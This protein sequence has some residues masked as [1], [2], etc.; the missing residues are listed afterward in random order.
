MADIEDTP[1]P[2]TGPDDPAP[3]SAPG[4]VEPLATSRLLKAQRLATGDDMFAWRVEAGASVV[5]LTPS[6]ELVR[7]VALDQTVNDAVIVDALQR[8]DSTAVTDDMILDA[9]RAI[10]APAPGGQG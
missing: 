5:G 10:A 1:P 6:P 7:R 8:V 9:L 4:L 3:T 2:I